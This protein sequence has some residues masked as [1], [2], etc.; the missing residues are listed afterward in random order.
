MNMDFA[1]PRTELSLRVSAREKVVRPMRGHKTY[2]HRGEVV[3]RADAGVE[4]QPRKR[5]WL[6]GQLQPRLFK[7]IDV[8]R[9]TCEQSGLRP[10]FLDRL[11][12]GPSLPCLRGPH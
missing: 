8:L 10:A 7:V 6:A 9:I 5:A 11:E 12:C 1:A 3:D 2:S 4:D